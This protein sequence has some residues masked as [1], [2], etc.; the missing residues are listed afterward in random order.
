MGYQI[1]LALEIEMKIKSKL[2][3]SVPTIAHPKTHDLK[4]LFC[5]LPQR[6]QEI[7]KGLVGWGEQFDTA[8]D[9]I[10][11][12]FVDFRYL[13]QLPLATTNIPF[14]EKLCDVIHSLN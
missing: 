2:D 14:M 6:V 9:Q 7:V 4:K 5:L 10:K 11:L 3:R 12:N 13:E 1:L 8:L